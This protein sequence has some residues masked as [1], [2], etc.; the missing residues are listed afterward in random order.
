MRERLFT[1][2][3]LIS[4]KFIPFGRDVKGIFH[5]IDEIKCKYFINKLDFIRKALVIM[6]K[7]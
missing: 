7:V 1:D 3:K 4:F 6:R 5:Y 2:L